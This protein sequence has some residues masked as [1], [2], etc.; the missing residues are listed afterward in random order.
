MHQL[1]SI[2]TLEER[3]SF[4]SMPP[5]PPT[6]TPPRGT[7]VP[8][9]ITRTLRP[10]QNSHQ[11]G[12]T[13]PTTTPRSN[14]IPKR[15]QNKET[16]FSSYLTHHIIVFQWRNQKEQ[17]KREE[18]LLHPRTEKGRKRNRSSLRRHRKRMGQKDGGVL[19]KPKRT[20]R[21][22]RRSPRKHQRRAIWILDPHGNVGP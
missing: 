14:P 21:I 7:S 12:V 10:T 20:P 6:P 4:L 8:P 16:R 18:K 3:L 19:P 11:T 2:G 15:I 13:I 5:L 17:R 1:L 9:Q 22:R